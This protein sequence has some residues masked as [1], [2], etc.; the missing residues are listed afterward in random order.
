MSREILDID[1]DKWN[2]QT[3]QISGSKDNH[4]LSPYF[5]YEYSNISG[6][7]SL[8]L[9]SLQYKDQKL[10]I[11]LPSTLISKVATYFTKDNERLL[12]LYIETTTKHIYY[13]NKDSSKPITKDSLFDYFLTKYGNTLRTTNIKTILDSVHAKKSLDYDNLSEEI[14]KKLWRGNDIYFDL[15]QKP[16][17]NVQNA[18][19]LSEVTGVKVIIK[20]TITPNNKFLEVNHAPKVTG[21]SFHIRGFSNSS[22]ENVRVNDDFP[23]D[24]LKKFTV[25]YS[26]TDS[27]YID[28]LLVVLTPENL[29]GDP[30]YVSSKYLISKHNDNVQWEM[31]RVKDGFVVDHAIEE[32]LK[33]IQENTKLNLEK[34]PDLKE[35]LKDITYDLFI[36][37]T[38]NF[39]KNEGQYTSDDKQ[40][41][42][43]KIVSTGYSFISHAETF[44]GFTVKE[45]KTRET[46][47]K[48]PT[49][50]INA[51][52]R[53]LCVFYSGT[54][55]TTDPL[56][57]YFLERSGNAKWIYRYLG[58]KEWKILSAGAPS[59]YTD[60]KRILELLNEYS[61]SSVMVDLSNTGGSYIPDGNTLTFKVTSTEDPPNSGFWKF[62]HTSA[63]GQTFQVKSVKH[64][65]KT[66]LS[67]I[68]SSGPLDSVSAYYY[69]G[70]TPA[71]LTRLLLIELSSSGG[72]RHKYFHRETKDAH[73]WSE[74][75]GSGGGSK[76]EDIKKTLDDLKKVQFPQEKQEEY[77]P[78]QT[79]GSSRSNSQFHTPGNTDPKNEKSR[80]EH[81]ESS[82]KEE[83]FLGGRDNLSTS[84][85][86]SS[87]SSGSAI[88]GGI[89]GGL[90]CLCILGVLIW[91]VGPSMRVFILSRNPPL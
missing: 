39:D 80:N 30:M 64:T 21:S 2:T 60:S 49:I 1:P 46:T 9:V 20:K 77:E 89:V 55:E 44:N 50:P 18:E 24:L 25:Y 91:K 38:R 8:K 41:P 43:R 76:L 73:T 86:D 29:T 15:S 58:D 63:T 69:G 10:Q 70:S 23:Y 17:N 33:N 7:S 5:K 68:S 65:E 52:I 19:Y 28:P 42:Y 26:L 74:Y 36:D 54:S 27:T 12:A 56:L 85:K 3:S 81:D 34:N 82:D 37:L 53:K 72:G 78:P 61:V 31:C 6:R 32:I 62:K 11:S 51:R 14:R 45:I 35:K 16:T 66:Q 90:A 84:S 83:R 40:I 47:I 13:T 88:A 75:H 57:I 79:T 87:D 48:H 67:G 71:D 59:S 22:N 4:T